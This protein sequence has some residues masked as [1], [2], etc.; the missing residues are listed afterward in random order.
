MMWDDD[1]GTDTI[2]D[3]LSAE[4]CAEHI[5]RAERTGFDAAPIVTAFGEAIRDDV[6]NNS[7]V[8][9]DDAELAA[10]LWARAAEHVPAF[11][12]GRQ[13]IGLNERFR[14]YRYRPGQRFDWHADGAFR[15]ANGEVSQLSFI[16]YLNDDFAGGE[17][18]IMDA[19]IKPK[20]GMALF[21]R[22]ELLHEGRA[23]LSGTKYV[24][25]SDVMYGR[26]GEMRG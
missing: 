8:M 22:H 12:K 14:T 15:R 4:E 6:R 1:R 25:R 18:A 17:T 26:I 11:L 2:E 5:A 13:A 16:M 21:F 20:R 3:I 24:L 9:V 10:R 19:V 7:R 23:V